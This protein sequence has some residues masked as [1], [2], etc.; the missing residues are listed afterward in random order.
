MP[1]LTHI[2]YLVL[3]KKHC[4]IFFILQLNLQYAFLAKDNMY[5]CN[6][7]KFVNAI[8]NYILIQ[9]LVSSKKAFVICRIEDKYTVWMLKRSHYHL[10]A[11]T[12]WI[13]QDMS[14]SSLT[15][16]QITYSNLFVVLKKIANDI[17]DT[18]R[19]TV[20][21]TKQKTL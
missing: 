2:K 8:I 5:I 20:L 15:R 11:Y 18:N 1:S 17:I 4:D 13:A 14:L 16:V 3:S 6:A 10:Y 7:Q 9:Y 12:L 21:S 19:S